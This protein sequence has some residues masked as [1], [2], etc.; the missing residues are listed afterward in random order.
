M[1]RVQTVTKDTNSEFYE[2]ISKFKSKTGCSVIVN[3][4]FNVRGEPIVCSPTD[5]FNCFMEQN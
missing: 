5:A 4:S 1:A 3:T 2:L